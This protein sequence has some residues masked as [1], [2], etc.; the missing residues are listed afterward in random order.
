[1]GHV[2]TTVPSQVPQ[3]HMFP[4]P[5]WTNWSKLITYFSLKHHVHSPI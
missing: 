5:L 1:M 4:S 2:G 3:V